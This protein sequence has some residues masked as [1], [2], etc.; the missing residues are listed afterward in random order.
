VFDH[1]R[2]SITDHCCQQMRDEVEHRCAEHPD[3]YDCPE[4][5]VRY[6]PNFDEY[7]LIV[8]DG[9]ASYVDIAYCPWC[10][11]RLPRSKRERWWA[12]MERLGIDPWTE[13]PPPLYQSD[14]W[15][16]SDGPARRDPEPGDPEP[17]GPEPAEPE[18]A[19]A[20]LEGPSPGGRE[21]VSR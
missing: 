18:P 14:A 10:G 12:E 17:E 6:V 8:H 11:T 19:P 9:G 3:P 15:Y 13:T 16:R 4:H 2:I 7:G 20:E 1:R 21:P 5:L